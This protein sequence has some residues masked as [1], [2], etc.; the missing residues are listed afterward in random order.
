MASMNSSEVPDNALNDQACST[1]SKYRQGPWIGAL[2]NLGP[3]AVLAMLVRGEVA[4]LDRI[5]GILLLLVGLVLRIAA[6]VSQ[7]CIVGSRAEKGNGV[8][9]A[10]APEEERE[11]Q[12]NESVAKI[13]K[14]H[15]RGIGGFLLVA[16]ELIIGENLESKSSAEDEDGQV[17]G[18][19]NRCRERGSGT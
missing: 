3:E 7:E 17:V 6:D 12:V 10:R 19:L 2:L 5:L 4:G 16:V 14:D 9:F 13:A 15:K 18:P 11:G 1:R 8:E